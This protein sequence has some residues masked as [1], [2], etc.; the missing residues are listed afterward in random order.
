M[1]VLSIVGARPQFIKAAVVSRQMRRAGVEELLVHSGQHYDAN[2]SDVFFREL[3]LPQPSYYL[4]IG[5]GRHGEQ[6]GRILAGVEDVLLKEDPDIVVI[7]GDTNT[8]LAGALAPVKLHI[9]VAHVEAG[10]RSYNRQ[11]PEEINRIVADHCSNLLFCPTETAV[12]N[13][14][15]EGFQ[16]IGPAGHSDAGNESWFPEQQRQTPLVVNVGDVMLDLAREVKVQLDREGQGKTQI[17]GRYGLRPQEYVLT[18]IHRASNTDESENLRSILAA[19]RQIARSGL[20]VLFP[21][22]PRTRKALAEADLSA[23]LDTRGIITS[24]PVSY[25][26]MIALESEARLLL[27]DSGGVQKEAYFFKVPCVV[28][29]EETEWTELVEIGWNRLAGARTEAILAATEAIL[30]EDF[31]HK[32]R[33]DYYGTGHAAAR[34]VNVLQWFVER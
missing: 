22:H 7:Y 4:G 5:S 2:M 25:V 23:L 27:T 34:I 10:L 11:M 32:P 1:K 31:A 6:T 20:K 8:T 9:P 24:D 26:E 17:L 14:K 21:I 12:Q 16:N 33:P 15:R 28:A 18:T 3:E 19:L 13:L 30:R 29:R